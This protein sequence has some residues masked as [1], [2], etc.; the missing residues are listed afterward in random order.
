MITHR[1]FVAVGLNEILKTAEVPK[2][3]F[4]HY[5]GSKEQYGCELLEQYVTEYAERLD[6]LFG[7]REA[8]ARD[9]LLLLARVA[10]RTARGR[11]PRINVWW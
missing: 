8:N 5:F 10:T 6:Q 1:G 9:K 2:G 11:R 7:G 3:S 4:Y